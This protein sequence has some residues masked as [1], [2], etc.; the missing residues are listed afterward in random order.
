[1]RELERTNF[2]GKEKFQGGYSGVGPVGSATPSIATREDH[3]EDVS[4]GRLDLAA[5]L[6]YPCRGSGRSR[7]IL[8]RQYV[9][10]GRMPQGQDRAVG[11]ADDNRLSAGA[12]GRR[13]AA[14]R[15]T[16]HGAAAMDCL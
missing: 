4:R 16:A 9:R 2:K 13:A 10:D 3:A 7:T 11:Q 6:G 14:A 15:A 5:G 12:E 8:R 1:M